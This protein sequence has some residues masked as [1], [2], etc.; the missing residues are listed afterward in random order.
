[1][2]AWVAPLVKCLLCAQVRTQ[3]P[4]IEPCVG[5]RTQQEAYFSLSLCL[6]P[7]WSCLALSLGEINLKKLFFFLKT[8]FM[9]EKGLMEMW[10]QYG[11]HIILCCVFES[12]QA[13]LKSVHHK[14]NGFVTMCDDACSLDLLW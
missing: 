7:R 11:D 10:V 5:L 4:G 13:D 2:G 12:C 8:L 3:G 6:S 14:E 1:M 9:N